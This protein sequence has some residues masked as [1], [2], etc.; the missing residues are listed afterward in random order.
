MNCRMKKKIKKFSERPF[1]DIERKS[2]KKKLDAEWA[3]KQANEGL[4][5]KYLLRF[6]ATC[7]E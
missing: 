2:K 6:S 7:L 3:S 1:E 5:E 4:I